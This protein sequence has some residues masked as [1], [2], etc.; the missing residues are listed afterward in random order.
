V[1]GIRGRVLPIEPKS[2]S[3]GTK[4]ARGFSPWTRCEFR[5]RRGA[6]PESF[7][8]NALTNPSIRLRL[9]SQSYVAPRRQPPKTTQTVGVAATNALPAPLDRPF[10]TLSR[11]RATPPPDLDQM[12]AFGFPA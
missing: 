11:V 4:V 7:A 6:T 9:Y 10:R 5:V 8:R 3:D 2:R 1:S 12:Q